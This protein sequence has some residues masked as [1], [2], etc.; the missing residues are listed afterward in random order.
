MRKDETV[1]QPSDVHAINP[2]RSGTGT[3]QV[4]LDDMD[5][6]LLALPIDLGHTLGLADGRA[7]V[8]FTAAT[9]RRY[10]EHHV[11]GWQ[12]CEGAGGCDA[13]MGFC[14]AFGCNPLFPSPDFG[15][16]G[17][18]GPY[19]DLER[20]VPH[21]TH[22]DPV[23]PDGD[24][25]WDDGG[26]WSTAAGDHYADAATAEEYAAELGDEDGR[27]DEKLYSYGEKEYDSRED[28][29]MARRTS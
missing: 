1:S 10:Q 26:Q 4:F 9:G 20:G 18:A 16:S 19:A 2:M 7:W 14:E 17:S 22:P 28:S 29:Y 11:L 23:P 12:F 8:G 15:E 6:A 3:L 13:P 24:A 25:G 5:A 27:G 21:V